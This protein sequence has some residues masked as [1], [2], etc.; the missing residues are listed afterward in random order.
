MER[1][2]ITADAAFS[3]LSRISQAENIKLA[4]IAHRLVETGKLPIVSG[5]D[6]QSF[7]I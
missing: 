7:R 1:H 4:E 6:A 3:V 5:P 2:G